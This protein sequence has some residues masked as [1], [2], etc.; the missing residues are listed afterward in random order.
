[1]KDKLSNERRHGKKSEVR[2]QW[3]EAG[4]QRPAVSPFCPF[5]PFRPFD[6][7]HNPKPTVETNVISVRRDCNGQSIRAALSR[8]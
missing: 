7:G 2:S 5:S 1:M 4:N 6:P 3:S 8:R